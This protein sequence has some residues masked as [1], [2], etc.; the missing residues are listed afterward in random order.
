MRLLRCELCMWV[1]DGSNAEDLNF[2]YLLQ[3]AVP[4]LKLIVLPHA[5]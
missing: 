2:A 1:P 4:R 3:P 5:F